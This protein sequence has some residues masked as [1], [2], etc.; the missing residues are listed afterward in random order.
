MKVLI[1][2]SGN[3]TNFDIKIHQAFIYDQV[4]AIKKLDRDIGFDYF[5]IKG[6][7]SAIVPSKSKITAFIELIFLIL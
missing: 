1:V 3:V 4:E 7:V 6:K 5:F 2:C